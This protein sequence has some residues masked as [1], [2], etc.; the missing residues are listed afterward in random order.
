[1][2]K[3]AYNP[4]FGNF[5]H[6]DWYRSLYQSKKKYVIHMQ[7]T[8]WD[9]IQKEENNCLAFVEVIV[10]CEHHRIKDVMELKYDWNDEVILQFYSTMYLDEKSSKLFW[11]T[12]DEIY[13]VSLVRCAAILGLQD[14]TCYPK[15]LCDDCVMELN[16]MRFMYE[17]DEYKLS[18]VE[19][20]KPFFVLHWLLR[21][22][23]SPREGDSSRVPQ[24]ERNILHA[25]SEKERFNVFDFIFQ[26]I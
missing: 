26:E 21:K 15:R 12:K 10:V 22:T 2:E 4:R 13:S 7:W 3:E 19:Y 11:M 6:A 9:F 1:V 8:D 23:L 25:I 24:Y 20:F 17:K 18:K 16:Q 14:H 5:F